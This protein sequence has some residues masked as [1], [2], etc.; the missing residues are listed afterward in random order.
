MNGVAEKTKRRTKTLLDG[1]LIVGTAG[2]K[3]TTFC[4]QQPVNNPILK[5]RHNA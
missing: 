5:Q 1:Y 3:P 4:S 2:F